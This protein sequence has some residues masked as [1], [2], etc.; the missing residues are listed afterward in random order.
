MLRRFRLIPT[1]RGAGLSG[2]EMNGMKRPQPSP[3][4]RS[5]GIPLYRQIQQRLME[6]RTQA[7]R[8]A[9]FDSENRRPDGSDPDAVIQYGVAV[10]NRAGLFA[11]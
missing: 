11:L 6:R 7:G 3:L 5:S 2:M 10:Y 1:N 9:A 8:T 4:D